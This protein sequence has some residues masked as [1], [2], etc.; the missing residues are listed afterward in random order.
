MGLCVT[1]SAELGGWG[2]PGNQTGEAILGPK[3]AKH[4]T[5]G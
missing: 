3:P 1:D 4:R 2:L 5:L